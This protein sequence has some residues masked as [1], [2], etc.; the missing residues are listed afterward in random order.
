MRTVKTQVI[1]GKIDGAGTVLSGPM[2]CKKTSTGIY[3]LR[4]LPQMGKLIDIVVTVTNGVAWTLISIDQDTDF[5]CRVICAN[6]GGT[7]NIDA[8]FRYIATIEG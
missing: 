8:P 6:T 3:V 5:G 1:S 7:L 4:L 2:S